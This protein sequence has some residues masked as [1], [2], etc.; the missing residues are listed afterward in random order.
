MPYLH[1]MLDGI[2]LVTSITII[3]STAILAYGDCSIIS[4]E[5]NSAKINFLW[6]TFPAGNG[7]Q[8]IQ[9]NEK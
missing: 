4:L 1:M 6:S 9:Q 2:L 8:R 3:T 5:P 7:Q